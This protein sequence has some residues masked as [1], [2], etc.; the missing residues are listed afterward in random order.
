[1]SWV[2]LGATQ[3]PEP[4]IHPS[5][6]PNFSHQHHIFEPIL[7]GGGVDLLGP[8]HIPLPKSFMDSVNNLVLEL[9]VSIPLVI[10]DLP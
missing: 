2:T 3:R 6:D 4:S 7:L 9:V 10:D 5:I 1:M 8:S